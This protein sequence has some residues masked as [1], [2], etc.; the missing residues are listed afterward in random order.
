MANTRDIEYWRYSRD[1]SILTKV[2]SGHLARTL[3]LNLLGMLVAEL[4]RFVR[5]TELQLHS[6]EINQQIRTLFEQI[7]SKVPKAAVCP[8]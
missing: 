8:E 7:H 4:V 1:R 5:W 3:S 2:R 6:V